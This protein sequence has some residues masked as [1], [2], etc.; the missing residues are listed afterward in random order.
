MYPAQLVELLWRHKHPQVNTLGVSRSRFGE[1]NRAD[2][3]VEIPY[4][5]L[6]YA[7]IEERHDLY[8]VPANCIPYAPI[9]EGRIDPIT[10][11]WQ[12]DVVR[13]WRKLLADLLE[14]GVLRHADELTYLIGEDSCKRQPKEF[15]RA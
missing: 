11:R 5:T 10:K 7:S 13:G 14:V 15:Q 8:L 12:G 4:G 3:G 2:M 9:L 1:R 6:W